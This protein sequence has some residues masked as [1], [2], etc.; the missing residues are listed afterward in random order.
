MTQRSDSLKTKLTEQSLLLADKSRENKHLHQ[1]LSR[2]TAVLDVKLNEVEELRMEV[3]E[4]Q[5]QLRMRESERD[6][7]AVLLN[8]AENAERKSQTDK[9]YGWPESVRSVNKSVSG[10]NQNPAGKEQSS[11]ANHFQWVLE[12]I[13]VGI[14][15]VAP[16]G[17][18]L[19]ANRQLLQVTGYSPG[20]LF[21]KEVC[22]LFE[23]HKGNTALMKNLIDSA[24]TL[25]EARIK[26]KDRT[27]FLGA[28]VMKR[29]AVLPDKRMLLCV[30]DLA[31]VRQPLSFE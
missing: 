27:G 4:T 11:D 23:Q 10:Q 8:E 24:G 29:M 1:E 3:L 18:I 13:P 20:D 26:R 28:V 6:L 25:V 30:L 12:S 9:A 16:E 7:L 14:V 21:G 15:V 17:K 22:V 2:V 31:E 5:Q 19:S